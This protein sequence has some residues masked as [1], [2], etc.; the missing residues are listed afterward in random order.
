VGDHAD[1]L[2]FG[3]IVRQVAAD[4]QVDRRGRDVAADPA[5][6]GVVMGDDAG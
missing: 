4:H 1:N 2:L 6:A 3:N 5:A